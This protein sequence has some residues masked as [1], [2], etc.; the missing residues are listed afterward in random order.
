MNETNRFHATTK[1]SILLRFG[2]SNHHKTSPLLWI[3]AMKDVVRNII[4]KDPPVRRMNRNDKALM[5]T[6]T[7]VG[8]SDLKL[9]DRVSLP[10]SKAAFLQGI[11]V[12]VG[13][14]HFAEGHWVGVQLTG[15]SLGKG[16]CD[17]TYKGKRYFGNVGPKNGVMAPINK[18]NKRHGNRTGDPKVDK[19]QKQRRKVDARMA[20]MHFIDC[21]VEERQLALIKLAEEQKKSRFALF[22]KEQVHITRL[23]QIRFEQLMRA[24]GVAPDRETTNAAPPTLK[25][26]TP[27]STLCKPDMDLV[28]GLEMTQQNYCLS[29]PLLPDNPITFVSQAFLNMTGYHINEILGKNC[30]FLQG[31]ETDKFH[32]NRI[33]LAIQE[34]S[35]C[36]VCLLNYRKNGK[37]FYNRLFMTALRDT[38]GRIKNY[39]GVQ[40]EVT[41]EVAARINREEVQKTEA[42]LQKARQAAAVPKE[43]TSPQMDDT[44]AYYSTYGE[45]TYADDAE[46]GDVAQDDFEVTSI[47]MLEFT[48][49]STPSSSSKGKMIATNAKK[50]I[51]SPSTHSRNV[52][53]SQDRGLPFIPQEY[54][55]QAAL[56]DCYMGNPMNLPPMHTA[57]MNRSSSNRSLP[58]ASGQAR[59]REL[60]HSASS[61]PIYGYRD[62]QHRIPPTSPAKLINEFPPWPAEVMRG[63]FRAPQPPNCPGNEIRRAAPRQPKRQASG[64]FDSKTTPPISPRRVPS[65]SF[66]QRGDSSC[67]DSDFTPRAASPGGGGFAASDVGLYLSQQDYRAHAAN[68]YDDDDYY[69]DHDE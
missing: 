21:L 58:A 65:G 59:A 23:K 7:W 15:P 50:P 44:S 1:T 36:Q 34:G 37:K 3:S 30:R 42:K 68:N 67:S 19:A 46:Y 40:C 39:L 55:Q 53:A 4:L 27:G 26:S 61:M 38:K 28:D 20:D 13:K 51:R 49:V 25:Y 56:A 33:R 16:D 24:R 48:P 52:I 57:K 64:S 14:V 11:V 69:V 45:N 62:P 60:R 6:S 5:E 66:I 22:D 29:D 9:E 10:H 2:K 35:D 32:V 43:A 18:V 12:Y 47:K 54:Y 63:Q 8:N 31:P 41:A 17:G